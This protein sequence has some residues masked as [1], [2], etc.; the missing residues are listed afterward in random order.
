MR[1]EF[2]QALSQ[3]G[4]LLLTLGRPMAL[5]STATTLWLFIFPPSV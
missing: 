4:A 3:N 1:L 5:I 2:A